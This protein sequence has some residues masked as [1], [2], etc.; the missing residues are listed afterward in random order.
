MAGGTAPASRVSIGAAPCPECGDV[1]NVYYT[2]YC[3]A[4]PIH[5]VPVADSPI[6]AHAASA[7]VYSERRLLLRSCYLFLAH[8]LQVGLHR[9][10]DHLCAVHFER[11]GD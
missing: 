8:A 11:L 5:S 2:D 1:M 9:L 3:R 7:L 10:H 6:H 4:A